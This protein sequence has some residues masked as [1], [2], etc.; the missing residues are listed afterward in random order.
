[1]FKVSLDFEINFPNANNDFSKKFQDYSS[2]LIE[3]LR[4]SMKNEFVKSMMG[5][6]DGV[7][8]N[9]KVAIIIL[10]LHSFLYTHKSIGGKGFRRPAM[11]DSVS[12]MMMV[13]GRPNLQLVIN[14][15]RD[16][17][18]KLGLTLQPFIIVQGDTYSDVSDNIVLVLDNNKYQFK[19]ILSALASLLKCYELF[20]LKWPEANAPVYTFLEFFFLNINSNAIPTKVQQLVQQL[21]ED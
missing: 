8:E 20:D 7:N 15:R 14:E 19:S 4:K 9:A 10:A 16:E 11:L 21:S 6:L 17:M 1:M 3:V 18:L 5:K 2:K 12:Y 13:T